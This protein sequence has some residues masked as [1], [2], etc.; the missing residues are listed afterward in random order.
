M[1][2]NEIND[3]DG[4]LDQLFQSARS[5]APKFKF[6]EVSSVFTSALAIG[7]A[8][9]AHAKVIT[10]SIFKSKIFIMS[11]S[12]ITAIT[13]AVLIY[14]SAAATKTPIPVAVE[15]GQ[16]TKTAI[17]FVDPQEELFAA[18]DTLKRE[19]ISKDSVKVL[20]IDIHDNIIRST[21]LMNDETIKE[22]NFNLNELEGLNIDL[23]NLSSELK[24]NLSELEGLTINLDDL[25]MDF[26]E[27]S[28]L[29]EIEGLD[30]EDLL[31]NVEIV[32]SNFDR[33]DPDIKTV[34]H[35]ITNHTTMEELDVIKK[36]ATKAGIRFNYTAKVKRNIIKKIELT[37]R[38]VNE[39]GLRK[40]SCVNINVSNDKMFSHTI[41]WQ[42]NAAGKAVSFGRA[43]CNIQKGGRTS[44][45]RIINPPN[46]ANPKNPANPPNPAPKEG[47]SNN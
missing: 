10:S 11:I 46:P 45:I 6:T 36:A 1:K 34:S 17:T 43:K 37:M 28:L 26:E 18:D 15:E 20:T 9:A 47:S 40:Y 41:E 25:E 30:V 12:T 3:N 16:P 7:V 35:F 21:V 14:S 42:E 13:S 38:L 33:I 5:E 29:S 8:T 19:K 22:L 44:Q 4:Q 23:D 31:D 39:E 24:V 32:Y 27:L 2:F